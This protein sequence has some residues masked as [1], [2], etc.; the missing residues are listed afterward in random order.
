M[1][2]FITK[3]AVLNEIY[4]PFCWSILAILYF[5]RTV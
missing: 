2:Y 3:D 1:L 5:R 4:F